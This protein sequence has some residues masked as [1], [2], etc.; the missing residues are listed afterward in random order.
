MY[1]FGQLEDRVHALEEQSSAA[2]AEN[3]SLRDIVKRLQNE[4]RRLRESSFTFTVPPATAIDY[5]ATAPRQVS[6]DHVRPSQHPSRSAV[7]PNQR[8]QLG[9][10]GVPNNDQMTIDAGFSLPALSETPYMTLA[11]NPL[12]TSYRD[13]SL[14]HTLAESAGSGSHFPL[15][16]PKTSTM[17]WQYDGRATI[18]NSQSL[19]ELFAGS[20]SALPGPIDLTRASSEGINKIAQ[21]SVAIS[22]SEVNASSAFIVAVSSLRSFLANSVRQFIVVVHAE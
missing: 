2:A 4:N 8:E 17:S 9:H 13:A 20:Y 14:I 16:A 3:D 5:L 7:E 11:T 6:E 19:D 1:L 10:F 18:L 15:S 21:S 12:F 22:S